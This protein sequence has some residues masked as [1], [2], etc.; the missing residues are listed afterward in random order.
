MAEYK[1]GCQYFYRLF[2][3]T[4]HGFFINESKIIFNTTLP[5]FLENKKEYNWKTIKKIFKKNITKWQIS[6][7]KRYVDMH[8]CG[9]HF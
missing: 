1:N 8:N 6:S 9:L 2:Y 3:F 4:A 5:Q 7:L